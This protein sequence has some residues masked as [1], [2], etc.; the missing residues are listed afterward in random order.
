MVQGIDVGDP[1][2]PDSRDQKMMNRN[3]LSGLRTRWNKNIEERQRER[4]DTTWGGVE[5][6]EEECGDA[7][8]AGGLGG[9][10]GD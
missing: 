2:L 7:R 9:P 3:S 10:K 6:M 1:N 8:R 5:G 4:H